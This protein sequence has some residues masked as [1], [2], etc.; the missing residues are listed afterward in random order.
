L[1]PVGLI[2]MTTAFIRTILRCTYLCLAH[3]IGAR[4]A[5]SNKYVHDLF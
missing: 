1:K 5:L 4:T 2:R 3:E